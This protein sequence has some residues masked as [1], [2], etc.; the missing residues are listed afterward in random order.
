MT[1]TES[2][3]TLFFLTITTFF[4]TSCSKDDDTITS[5]EITDEEAVELVEA[6]LQKST[7]GLN[8]TTKSY[9]E[10]LTTDI[11]L[12]ELCDTLYEETFP[13]TFNGNFIEAE[14]NIDWSYQMNCNNLNIPETV[15]FDATS[16][17]TYTTQRIESNDSSQASFN[18]SGLQPTADAY[19]FNGNFKR[20]GNQKI[21]INQKTKSI[22]SAL[23]I[24]ITDITVEKV[25]YEIISGNG[26]LNLTG[27]TNE[28]NSFSFEGSIIFNGNG[29][30]TLTLNGN[31]YEI[32]L[33]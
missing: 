18:I 22:N 6:S 9:S 24:E 12:N 29:A 31:T 15:E 27:T 19:V 25:A 13:Y 26:L 1:I 10:E 2:I 21:T 4:L 23:S 3:K 5:T 7:G 30:A 32:S 11:T 33:N 17:G 16:S 20:D 28:G 8:E 14:Y